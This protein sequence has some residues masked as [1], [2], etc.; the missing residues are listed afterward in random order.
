MNHHFLQA[1]TNFCVVDFHFWIVLVDHWGQ[2]RY[3]RFL[4]CKNL[5]Y[6]NYSIGHKLEFK[7]SHF[8][9]FLHI[10]LIICNFFGC[11]LLLLL[12]QNHARDS[13]KTLAHSKWLFC[14]IWIWQDSLFFSLTGSLLDLLQDSI[15]NMMICSY[16]SFSPRDQRMIR[17]LMMQQVLLWLL[18]Y[19]C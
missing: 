2:T 9:H 3:T 4:D 8:T 17:K 12:I 13:F 7:Y 16:A 5:I 6:T 18:T 1:W 10:V 19:S 14:S 11:K 15:L